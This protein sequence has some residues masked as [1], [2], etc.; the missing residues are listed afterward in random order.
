[1][2]APQPIDFIPADFHIEFAYRDEARQRGHFILCR[3]HHAYRPNRL[4]E[5]KFFDFRKTLS[6]L[7]FSVSVDLRM[8]NRFIKRNFRRPLR[9]RVVAFGA[10][11]QPDVHRLD[12]VKHLGGALHEQICQ[13]RRYSGIDQ[14][15][16]VFFFESLCVTK[17]LRSEWMARQVGTQ[18]HVVRPQPQR[19]PQHDLVKKRCRGVD[20][21]V[22][23]LGRLYDSAQ[24]SR[25]HFRDGN[26]AFLAQEAPRALR[27]TVAAPDRMSL[28]LQQLCE[29]GTGCS[30]SQNEDP[31]GVAKTLSQST[32]PPS[33]LALICP[34][35]AL[36]A[37]GVDYRCNSDLCGLRER[38][39]TET[40]AT[41][42]EVSGT[43][44]LG[45]NA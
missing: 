36:R 11:I 42:R 22:A 19:R 45:G 10:L 33:A 8:R 4:G 23:A 18:I 20:D 29:K 28:P 38:H 12:L 5:A 32:P 26:G 16:A 41:S 37:G 31:H 13:P 39:P 43:E 30:G 44:G 14:R 24:I 17:L 35:C 25:V 3:E 21:E 2:P 15:R 27:V 6:E 1:M 7:K 9:N 40:G 34:N